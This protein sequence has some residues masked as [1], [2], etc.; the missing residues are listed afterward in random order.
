[1]VRLQK[2][3]ADAG[4]ASRRAAERLIVDGRVAVDGSIVRELGT[5]VDERRVEVEVDGKVVRVRRKRHIALHK[6]MGFISSRKDPQE[7]QTVMDLLPREWE[8]LYPVGRLDADSEGLLLITNDGDFCLRV[9][10][11]RYGVK[12]TYVAYVIGRVDRR[13]LKRMES[14]LVHQGEKLRADQ[15]R[16]I[17]AN[18]SH[19]VVEIDLHEGKNREVRRLFEAQGMTVERLRRIKIGPVKLGELPPGKWRTLTDAEIKSLLE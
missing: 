19:S 2:Y 12:K 1:M 7:R 9:S 16:L 4:V 15:T 8:N 11:P 18:N 3:L 17:S 13:A 14:G 5:R 10:H 6:P